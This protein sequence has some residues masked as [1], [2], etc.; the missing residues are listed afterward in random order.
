M[1]NLYT[2]GY[3][4]N[5]QD[6]TDEHHTIFAVAESENEA[7]EIIGNVYGKSLNWRTIE[8]SLQNQPTMHTKGEGFINVTGA[9]ILP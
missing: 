6:G 4:S 3:H 8:R 7:K 9:S 2:W 5:S 1:S